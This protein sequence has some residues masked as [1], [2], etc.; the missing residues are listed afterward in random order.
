MARPSK[1]DGV[2]YRRKG[3]QVLVDALSRP[4][5]ETVARN[6]QTPTTGMRRRGNYERRLQ[7]RD[8]NILDVV[9]KGEQ[10]EF[11][12]WA[13]F[14]LEN[15]SKPPM[16]AAKTHEINRASREAPQRCIRRSNIGDLTCRRI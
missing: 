14:F 13:D 16:R 1:H 9:R 7:A 5:R 15:Y 2:I 8:D 4:E 3:T 10:L 12:K 11:R 6:Q